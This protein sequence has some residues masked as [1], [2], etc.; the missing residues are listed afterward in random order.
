MVRL[1]WFDQT[2][3]FQNIRDVLNGSQKFPTNQ[4][5]WTENELTVCF[6]LVSNLIRGYSAQFQ[7]FRVNSCKL[8][9]DGKT[10]DGQDSVTVKLGKTSD[11]QIRD[12]AVTD[13]GQIRDGSVT[14]KTTLKYWIWRPK[15]LL[16]I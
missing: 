6:S 3:N 8:E 4:K 9:D 7:V 11:G 5:I 14:P 10:R 15:R 16:N 13:P 2:E 12:V 1:F